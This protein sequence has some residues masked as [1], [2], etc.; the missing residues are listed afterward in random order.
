VCLAIGLTLARQD[1]DRSHFKKKD[2]SFSHHKP[3]PMDKKFLKFCSNNTLAQA[4]LTQILSIIS[5][6]QANSSYNSI[7]KSQLTNFI[8][9]LQDTKNQGLLNS[10][11]EAFIKG[12]KAA[13]KADK[14]AERAQKNLLKTIEKQIK[15]VGRDITNE[16]GFDELDS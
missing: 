8:T 4:Y 15:Q 3:L 11:C 6:F 1:K 13:K 9:Y 2:L 7:L 12:L 5:A 14:E 10:D 16:K